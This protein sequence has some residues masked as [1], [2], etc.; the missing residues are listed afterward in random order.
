MRRR[1]ARLKP[2]RDQEAAKRQSTDVAAQPVMNDDDCLAVVQPQQVAHLS[3]R[4]QVRGEPAGRVAGVARLKAFILIGQEILHAQHLGVS[5]P[6]VHRT[7]YGFRYGL[8][9]LVELGRG[10]EGGLSA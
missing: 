10:S 3:F 5:S 7:A 4:E 8:R 1:G 9:S 6:S 2:R